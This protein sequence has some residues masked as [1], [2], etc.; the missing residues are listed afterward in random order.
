[1]KDIQIVR[2][3]GGFEIVGRLLGIQSI[4]TARFLEKRQTPWKYRAGIAELAKEKGVKIPPDY[5][6][7]RR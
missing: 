6:K 5:L 4:E 3:L 7:K 2:S 1:M